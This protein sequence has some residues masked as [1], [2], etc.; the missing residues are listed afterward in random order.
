ME[1]NIYHTLFACE[2]INNMWMEFAAFIAEQYQSEIFVVNFTEV[3][4][5]RISI[6]TNHVTNLLCL[7]MKQLIY[8]KKCTREPIDFRDFLLEIQNT[9]RI[10]QT[11]ARA[12]GVLAKHNKKWL[13]TDEEHYKKIMKYRTLF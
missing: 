4:L 6:K 12:K 13:K 5:N 7:I 2:I 10:E 8:R 9:E 3:L 1:D 11:I